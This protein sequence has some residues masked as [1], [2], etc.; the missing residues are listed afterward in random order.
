MECP[1]LIENVK[2]DIILGDKTQ[3]LGKDKECAGKHSSYLASRTVK[4]NH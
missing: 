3:E 1:H 4:L 2:I